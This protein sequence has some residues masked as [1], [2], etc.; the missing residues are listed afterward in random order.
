MS[1]ELGHADAALNDS[2]EAAYKTAM[3]YT[4][5]VREGM[6]AS[7]KP[8]TTSEGGHSRLKRNACPLCPLSFYL[9]G[10]LKRHL[11]THTGEKPFKCP[12]CSHAANRK[13][14]M[15]WHM[16][17]QH[18][19]KSGLPIIMNSITGA[20]REPHFCPTCGKAFNGR[21]WKQNLEYHMFKHTGLKPFQCP[22]CRHSSALK[23]NLLRHIKNKH[24]DAMSQPLL[25][26]TRDGSISSLNFLDVA[27]QSF[28][29][30]SQRLLNSSNTLASVS[31]LNNPDLRY[32]ST[33][34]ALCGVVASQSSLSEDKAQQRF[35]TKRYVQPPNCA[36]SNGSPSSLDGS[37]KAL[38]MRSESF[39]AYPRSDT[40]DLTQALTL[41]CNSVQYPTTGQPGA[42]PHS[43]LYNG[44]L[45]VSSLASGEASLKVN[46]MNSVTCE[47]CGKSFWSKSDRARHMRI[48]TGE[49]PFACPF[50][51][52]RAN[53]NSSVVKTEAMR[54]SLCNKM[55][56]GRN[57]RQNLNFHMMIHSG[58]KPHKCPFCSHRSTFKSNI[59]KH[60]LR[61]HPEAF[62]KF[63]Q[64]TSE[65]K[66]RFLVVLMLISLCHLQESTF[67]ASNLPSSSELLARQVSLLPSQLTATQGLVC[68]YC[69]KVIAGRNRQQRLKFHL[70]T[71][72]GER[73]HPCPHCPYR[74]RLKY[75]LKKHVR[76][77]HGGLPMSP[78]VNEV[79]FN[80]AP[81][82]FQDHSEAN[83]GN[84]SVID[85]TS[86]TA[87]LGVLQGH[88]TTTTPGASS[89]TVICPICGK[90]LSGRNGKQKLQYHMVTHT[91]EKPF[92]CPYCSYRAALKFNL[93]SHVRNIHKKGPSSSE[94]STYGTSLGSMTASLSQ[95]S[96]QQ[97]LHGLLT[98]SLRDSISSFVD[99]TQNTKNVLPTGSELINSSLCCFSCGK[100]ITGR[101]R[102]QRMQYHLLTHTGQ[103]NHQCPHC[104][105]KALLKFTLDRHLRA[106][107]KIP[108]TD[109]PNPM[110]Q[111][112]Y[113]S[114][115][116]ATSSVTDEPY[117][118]ATPALVDTM[119]AGSA[120]VD[121]MCPVCAKTFAGRNR[122]Q[123]LQLHLR[124]H[125]GEKPFQCPFCPHRTSRKDHLK[126][127]MICLHGK[128]LQTSTTSHHQASSFPGDGNRR[129]LSR[130]SSY[131]HWTQQETEPRISPH[132][133]YRRETFPV[134]L[135]PASLEQ[136][137]Q[138]ETAHVCAT[139]STSC[140]KFDVGYRIVVTLLKYS[141]ASLLSDKYID[142]ADGNLEARS[143]VPLKTS[144]NYFGINDIDPSFSSQQ[145]VRKFDGVCPFCFKV[146]KG[147][148]RHQNLLHH[149]HIHTGARPY[150]CPLCPY[151]GRQQN[152]VKRHILI[153]HPNFFMEIGGRSQESAEAT[154][155][156]DAVSRDNTKTLRQDPLHRDQEFAMLN[157]LD[158]AQGLYSKNKNALSG[159]HYR[160]AQLATTL[161]NPNEENNLCPICGSSFSGAYGKYNLKK[162]LFIHQGEKP[163]KCSACPY[164]TIRKAHLKR[165]IESVHGLQHGAHSNLDTESAT[166]QTT[167][168]SFVDE[169][170]TSMDVLSVAQ[171][172]HSSVV[173][174]FQNNRWSQTKSR[175]AASIDAASQIS[176]CPECGKG[177][178]GV[179]RKYNIKKHMAIHTGLKTFQ[180]PYCPHNT[181][182]KGNL[183][184]HVLMVHNLPFDDKSRPGDV[185]SSYISSRRATTDTVTLASTYTPRVNTEVLNQGDCSLYTHYQTKAS[186]SDANAK[187]SSTPR[188]SEGSLN[189]ET[190][191]I[192][193]S[194]SS[195]VM[196][197]TI[198]NDQPAPQELRQVSSHQQPDNLRNE[199]TFA[200]LEKSWL[201]DPNNEI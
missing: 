129:H 192:H 189:A 64:V 184:T 152:H 82:A 169:G 106:V 74:S 141:E 40:S 62:R 194:E 77:M 159:P 188:H 6:P 71:H 38:V 166:L 66:L 156:G 149:M 139:S 175:P 101:N 99:G 9:M 95:L 83:E 76:S 180:C 113:S 164:S 37:T 108:A 86:L 1:Y 45:I 181:N 98:Q 11:L 128:M 171:E 41:T 14:N 177:F 85:G 32:S 23:F 122:R 163:F 151:T 91:G 182:K 65:K 25:P 21:N 193:S 12:H 117:T 125:T 104:P 157:F 61:I 94:V 60:A 135:L 2:V 3:S 50:C 70:L 69:G 72:T 191:T 130:M 42:N 68:Q 111:F 136:D 185:Q 48:H 63:N 199:I 57:K 174:A 178:R 27:E 29:S 155:A 22:F 10:D 134:P 187:L 17:S 78:G 127:H 35:C 183:K 131:L 142:V 112:Q 93:V 102:R 119:P 121:L 100:I 20:V 56:K 200:S 167:S 30:W 107:H 145:S 198:S 15:M 190:S 79:A 19:D 138:L 196:S 67:Y 116:I 144:L 158:E 46:N 47:I 123:R 44:G 53:Q 34:S 36:G 160:S 26:S 4:S 59:T 118:H 124:T 52:Y 28:E 51:S 170:H 120:F 153:Q 5:N 173:S 31:G 195:P 13:G 115:D 140:S 80:I 165:H 126:E 43:S 172:S 197:N 24:S 186:K 58:V 147:R 110:L 168:K 105:Y 92:Q 33:T 97:Q 75:N 87:C 90:Q 55:F 146:L 84:A 176:Y 150:K 103:K 18:G 7:S 133:A 73:P 88:A 8:L 81:A 154:D 16:A 201:S 54:C 109:A 132:G 162:H 179:Y 96:T 148:N 49:K 39:E 143:D 114:H 161:H 89:P 137:E